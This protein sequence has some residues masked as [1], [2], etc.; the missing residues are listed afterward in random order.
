MKITTRFLFFLSMFAIPAAFAA[1]FTVNYTALQSGTTNPVI[2]LV[3]PVAHTMSVTVVLDNGN[4]TTANQ[5]WTA[6]DIVSI[7]F[8]VN[9]GYSG[10]GPAILEPNTLPGD[11][12]EIA[13]GV[14][15]TDTNGAL[16]SV[17]AQWV[18]SVNTNFI[19]GPWAGSP[20]DL[21]W[22]LQNLPGLDAVVHSTF[23]PGEATAFAA[24]GSSTWSNPTALPSAS[25]APTLS[26]WMLILLTLML[27]GIGF[28]LREKYKPKKM[29]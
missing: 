25:P 7:A 16:I 17:P 11:G 18:D 6:A 1:P 21:R 26:Q 14:F 10:P 8:V 15:A 9:S 29:H 20:P 27:G 12:L 24:E 5:T 2:D 28:K 4:S 22:A 13:T 3:P 23:V 19:S